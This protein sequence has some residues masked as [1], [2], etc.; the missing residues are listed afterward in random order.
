LGFWPR[1][2]ITNCILIIRHTRLDHSPPNSCI[3]N[4]TQSASTGTPDWGLQQLC[5]S[6]RRH[7]GGGI[8]WTDQPTV[9]RL[10]TGNRKAPEICSKP[11]ISSGD[12]LLP[13]PILAICVYARKP[14]TRPVLP[15]PQCPAGR[16]DHNISPAMIERRVSHMCSS[17]KSRSW[18]AFPIQL[19]TRRSEVRGQSITRSNWVRFPKGRIPTALLYPVMY[20][21]TMNA[22]YR[23]LDIHRCNPTSVTLLL[24]NKPTH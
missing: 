13:N 10:A 17:L 4:R 24:V 8:V 21:N 9:S 12:W 18:A 7:I 20:K 16:N 23:R 5:K 1:L 14:M 22:P 19:Q 11:K 2:G 15:G 6:L 3:K